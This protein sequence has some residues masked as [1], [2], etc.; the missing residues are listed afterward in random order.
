MKK[1]FLAAIF[2]CL[3]FIITLAKVTEEKNYGLGLVPQVDGKFVFLYTRPYYDHDTVFKMTTL[4]FSN[5]PNK[6]VGAVLRKATK[7]ALK[8]NVE[9]DAIIT[10]PSQ[11][12]YA[13]KF[14]SSN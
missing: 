2:L 1:I 3:L 7:E 8:R 4:T 9:F 10:G 12:D 11:Y 6:A 5:D 14:K 13:I